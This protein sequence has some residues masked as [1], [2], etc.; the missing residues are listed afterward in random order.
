METLLGVLIWGAVTVVVIAWLVSLW[1]SSASRPA[2]P[3][4]GDPSPRSPGVPSAPPVPPSAKPA[5]PVLA[6]ETLREGEALADGL[7][8]GHYLTREHYE[9]ELDDLTA[10]LDEVREELTGWEWDP[11]GDD[12]D[13]D[14]FDVLD[15]FGVEPWYADVFDLEQDEG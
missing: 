7:V 2:P 4:T 11:A 3:P 8:I 5:P 12:A 1:G 14:E 6:D 9:R 13:L 15:G 10:Q